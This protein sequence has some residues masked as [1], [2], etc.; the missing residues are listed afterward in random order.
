MVSWEACN[1][2][3]SVWYHSLIHS[4][5]QVYSFKKAFIVATFWFHIMVLFYFQY[6][7]ISRYKFKS[8]MIYVFDKDLKSS[9]MLCEALIISRK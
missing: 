9:I 7:F 4:I 6:Y 1:H 3:N 2:F 8:A 5:E